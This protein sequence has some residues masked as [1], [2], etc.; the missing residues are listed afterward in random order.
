MGELLLRLSGISK[1]FPGV[2]ALADVSFELRGGEVH[3]ICGENGAGKSTLIKILSGA[4]RHDGGK[5]I[6]KGNPIPQMT[7]ERSFNLGIHTIYQENTLVPWLTV[8]E[9]LYIGQEIISPKTGL[10]DWKTAFNRTADIMKSLKMNIAPRS[11]CTDLGIAEQQAVQIAKALTHECKVVVMDEP[12]ASFGKAE[13]DN[14]FRIIRMLREEGKG[15]IYISHRLDEV[16]EIADRITVLRD[17]RYV[18]SFPIKEVT[19]AALIDSMVGRNPGDFYDKESIVLGGEM[20]RVENLSRGNAVKD[21]SFSVRRGEILGIYGM[22]GAG[23]TELARL[24]FGVDR[25]DRGRIFIKGI[26][27]HP[28]NPEDAI[29]SGLAFITEDRRVGGLVINQSIEDNMVLPSLRKFKNLFVSP[30]VVRS[31]GKQMMKELHI[32]A[33]G[34]GTVVENLSGGNQQKVVVA[35]WLY[36]GAEVYLFDEPTRGIDVGA[37]QELYNIC[38]NLAKQGKAV[39]FIT[40]DME[41]LLSMSDRVLVMREGRIA[42]E[43]PKENLTQNRVLYEAIGGEKID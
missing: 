17:G 23:R 39:V 40:S 16:F 15:I 12:T 32:K 42:A 34:P 31:V 27:I 11:F 37:K 10:I 43:I 20:F 30:K 9:N 36:A 41:E 29:K 18:R 25:A 21:V 6:F 5:I 33:P 35:K 4:L 38:M 24:I 13:I 26:E 8:A 19:K 14:L 2:Q 28:K 7:P 1:S 3:A 22:I